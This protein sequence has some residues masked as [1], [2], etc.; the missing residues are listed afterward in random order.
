MTIGGAA[1]V[2]LPDGEI[3]AGRIVEIHP[4]ERDTIFVVDLGGGRFVQ[5]THDDLAPIQQP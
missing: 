1:A 4:L 3:V 2:T 5:A